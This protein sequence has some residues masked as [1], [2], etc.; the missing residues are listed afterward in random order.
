MI[1][2]VAA[3]S[4]C[5]ERV[6]TFL[7]SPS[8]QD[9]RVKPDHSLPLDSSVV[10]SPEGIQLQSLGSDISGL[11]KLAAITIEHASIKPSSKSGFS[12]KNINARFEQG[13][14]S[15]IV[16]PVGCGKTTLLRAVRISFSDG[17]SYCVTYD[18]YENDRLENIDVYDRFLGKFHVW[19]EK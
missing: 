8:M 13:S 2:A 6:Q 12:L 16:G 15:M 17:E 3:S 7:L 10:S 19:K 5:L 18:C 1:P 9:S 11:P 4:G 14:L